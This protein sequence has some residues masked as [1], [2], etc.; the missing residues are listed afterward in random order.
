MSITLNQTDAAALAAV[1][2]PTQDHGYGMTLTV[3]D[4]GSVT[5]VSDRY[6][7]PAVTLGGIPASAVQAV[8]KGVAV[9]TERFGHKWFRSVD[10]DKLDMQN[11]DNCVLGQMIP[12]FHFAKTAQVVFGDSSE[13]AAMDH[14]FNVFGSDAKHTYSDLTR[15]WT[16]VISEAKASDDNDW[17]W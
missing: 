4:D 11:G 5:I 10:L 14:G 6:D 7:A 9:L 8:A 2:K 17:D 1:I 12:G 13:G 16:R 15:E 3:N